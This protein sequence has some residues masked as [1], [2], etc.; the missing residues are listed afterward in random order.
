MVKNVAY[1]L[2]RGTYCNARHTF[3]AKIKGGMQHLQPCFLAWWFSNFSWHQNQ[4]GSLLKNKLL[5]L[6]PEFLIQKVWHG[7][8][9][10]P[11]QC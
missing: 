6:T 1:L 7:N 9:E 5:G 3:L 10:F 8:Q 2:L 11:K 4:P